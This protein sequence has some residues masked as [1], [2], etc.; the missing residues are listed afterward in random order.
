MK[1]ILSMLLIVAMLLSMM[2]VMAIP[3]VAVDGEWSV[4]SSKDDWFAEEDEEVRSVAGYKYTE[5]GLSVVPAD[6]KDW[7]PYVTAQTTNEV[8]IRDGLYMQVRVDEFSYDAGDRWLTFHVWDSEGVAPVGCGDEYGYGVVA[9]IRLSKDYD[10][11]TGEGGTGINSIQW[12]RCLA[13]GE[14]Y[15]YRVIDESEAAQGS[16]QYDE[17]GRPIHTFEIKWNTTDEVYEAYVNGIKAPEVFTNALNKQF[18]N[19]KA[20]VGFS[21]QNNKLGGTAGFTVLKF[22][23]SEAT[24]TTPIGD[25]ER[26]PDNVYKEIAQIADADTVEAGQPAVLMTGDKYSSDLKATPKS[27]VTGALASVTDDGT[28]RLTL[29][30]STDG[31][32]FNVRNNV[33]Y[34]IADFPVVLVLTRNLCTCRWTD[35]DEDGE[36]SAEEKE[37]TCG[38]HASMYPFTGDIVAAADTH[39]ISKLNVSWDTYKVYN[40]E[41]E[42]NDSFLYFYTD[43]SGDDRFEGRIN[44]FRVDFNGVRFVDGRGTFDVCMMACF[45]TVDDAEEF[46]EDY[47]KD[48]FG[49]LVEAGDSDD[50]DPVDTTPVETNPVETNPVETGDDDNTTEKDPE[51]TTEKD[52]ENTTAKKPEKTTEKDDSDD[53]DQS[54]S[55]CGSVAG[56]GAIAVVAM[57][58]ACM[59]SFRKKED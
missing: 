10:A 23:T 6:W 29:G 11:E 13:V 30:A 3:T 51:N 42:Q 4:Y 28:I 17:E 45:R 46:V 24:A 53:K 5:E 16:V 7:T 34:D 58:A 49:D 9:M 55:G 43:L 27:G 20:Y 25:D 37:C 54:D 22:G 50:T 39:R 33:S 47:I 1:K 56:I 35:Y 40:E 15:T 12:F 2:I 52:P 18:S 19:G 36:Y 38:E 14:A 57:A 41:T 8:D 26:A 48:N 21:A 44:G 31:V 32:A 59:V